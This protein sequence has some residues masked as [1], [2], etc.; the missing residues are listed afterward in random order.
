MKILL[1]FYDLIIILCIPF[2]LL[3]LLIKSRFSWQVL[4]RFGNLG[5]DTLFKIKDKD[6]IWIHAVSLGEVATCKTMVKHLSQK[7][8]DKII[9]LTTITNTGMKLARSISKDNVISLYVPFDLSFIVNRFINLIKPDLLILMETEL[10]PNLL[11][12]AEKHK[13]STYVFNARLSDR[14][15]GKYKLFSWFIKNISKPIKKFCV[16]SE[17]D[18]ERFLELGIDS[19]KIVTTGNMKYDAIEELAVKTE[20][21]IT[22]LRQK[23]LLS[24]SD[25]LIVC[26][27]TH[28]REEE[29]ILKAYAELKNQFSGLRLLIAPRHLERLPLIE[30]LIQSMNLKAERISHQKIIS[31]DSIL[32]LDTIGQLM[33]VYSLA[34]LVIVGGSLVPVGGHNILEPAFF[35]KPIMVGPYMH[36]FRDMT[37]LFLSKDAL[38]QISDH[39]ELKSKISDLMHDRNALIGFG[40]SA[41]L[42]LNSKQ[43]A[44]FTNLNIIEEDIL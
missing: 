6:V 17:L 7:Y 12:Y 25:F 20:K 14:S 33:L 23:L 18:K 24:N 40:K 13:I 28:D 3:H 39:S 21:E 10:W 5:Y 27:S 9:L 32:L 37:Q 35:E 16:Q 29:Y 34:N 41:K 30:D 44:T 36:N 22:D 38:I 26:G 4:K 19:N 1:V 2:Y 8:H 31:K 43:G 15:F 42:V 11:Y